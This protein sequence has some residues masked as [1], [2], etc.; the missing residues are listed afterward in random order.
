MISRMDQ[1]PTKKQLSAAVY[2]VCT[3]GGRQPWAAFRDIQTARR[4]VLRKAAE[5]GDEVFTIDELPLVGG[6]DRGA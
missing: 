6:N 5:F 3:D 1:L 2:V 4:Y